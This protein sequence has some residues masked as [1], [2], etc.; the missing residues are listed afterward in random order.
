MK[1]INI[2]LLILL[3]LFLFSACEKDE[4]KMYP[5]Q[6]GNATAPTVTVEGTTN[7]IVTEETVSTFPSVLNWSR[8]N[9]GKDIVVEYLLEMDTTETFK[10]PYQISLGNSVYSKA[11]SGTDLSNWAIKF[12]GF[13]EE[14]NEAKEVFLNMR[15]A[16]TLRLESSSVI[17]SPDTLYSNIISLMVLAYV[18]EI[19]VKDAIY[20]TGDVISGVDTWSN[21]AAALGKG[22]QVL[23]ADNSKV[24][25]KK[26]TYTGSFAS[27]GFKL[28]TKAGNWDTSFA[29]KDGKLS[30]N[31]DGDNIP[32]PSASG[33]YTLT[34]DLDAL[35]HSF[36]P[37]T[38]T[39]NSYSRIGVIGSATPTGWDSDTAMEQVSPHIWVITDIEL[40]GGEI[41]FRANDGWD[42]NWGGS[43][44]DIPFGIGTQGGDNL[45]I[46]RD[47]KYFLALNDLTGH[48]VIIRKEKMP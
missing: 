48:Y 30:P 23:F 35:T 4:D 41:K 9:F 40:V 25:N 36:I 22:L 11:L 37:Y 31:N 13:D 45:K 29:Y 14:T 20:L 2:F 3:P 19:P 28:I 43:S 44:V 32:G 10:E 47:G 1:K 5:L 15:I 6:S 12:G 26:Y 33:L 21:D 38:E 24:D 7:I 18:P 46:E 8:A 16:A 17:N 42:I 39:A 34:V 27:G